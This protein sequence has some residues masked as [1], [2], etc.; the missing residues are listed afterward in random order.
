MKG[1]DG[2]VAPAGNLSMAGG[3]SDLDFELAI[4]IIYPQK[5]IVFQTDDMFYENDPNFGGFGG[6]FNVSETPPRIRMAGG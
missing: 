2:G 4:P 5:A 6:F 1:I 3:E